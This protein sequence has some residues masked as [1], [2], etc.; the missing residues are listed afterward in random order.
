MSLTS[1]STSFAN[2]YVNRQLRRPGAQDELI[3][4]GAAE[5]AVATTGAAPGYQ[6]ATFAD[7]LKSLTEYIPGEILTIYIAA[8]AAITNWNFSDAGVK[9]AYLAYFFWGCLLVAPLWVLIGVFLSSEARPNWR[10]FAWPMLA[11]PIAFGTYALA[12][13]SSWLATKWP[14]GALIATLLV[15][16]I[17]PILH[18]I[19]LLYAKILPPPHNGQS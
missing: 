3:P 8:L 13:P 10:A 9:Q 2:A 12:L 16:T 11:G 18:V 19:T 17:A 15:L 5:T 4:Q 1:L 7:N 6:N 14:N